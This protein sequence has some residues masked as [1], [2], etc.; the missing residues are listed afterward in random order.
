MFRYL[1]FFFLILFLIFFPF[2]SKNSLAQ[3]ELTVTIQVGDTIMTF[4]GKTSPNAQVSFMEN[5]SV[6]GTTVADNDGNFSKSL[7][8]QNPGVHLYSFYTTD[9]NGKTSSTV[10]YSVSLTSGT[11]T[12]LSS[13]V[14]PPTINLSGTGIGKGNNLKISGLTVASSTVTP[15]FSGVSHS[16]SASGSTISG[17]NGYWEYYFGTGDLSLGDYRVYAKTSTSE[18]HLSDSSEVKDFTVN[19]ASTPTST[20]SDSTAALTPTPTPTPT[21]VPEETL[22]PTPTLP[23]FLKTFDADNSGKIELVEL[24]GVVKN[25]V[26]SWRNPEDKNCDLNQDG[27]CDLIDFSVLMYYV[28]R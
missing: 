2:F 9:T 8:S 4:S 21:I 26:F 10:N 27:V 22:I 15:F 28:E 25:W 12:E 18:S 14:L 1:Y 3:T 7:L 6:L 24:F 11:E 16:Y 19:I 20:S 13:I 23:P 17:S 5:N